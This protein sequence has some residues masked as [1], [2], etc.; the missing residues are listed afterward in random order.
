MNKETRDILLTSVLLHT[1]KN[2]NDYSGPYI[3][4]KDVN[5]CIWNMYFYMLCSGANEEEKKE[6]YFRKFNES[7]RKL[8][9]EQQQMVKQEYIDIIKTQ[10]KNKIKKKGNDKYE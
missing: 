6:E 2:I 7:Y 5:E 9:Q 10:D 3:N 4:D 8:N 1:D